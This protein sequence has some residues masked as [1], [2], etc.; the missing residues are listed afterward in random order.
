MR[1]LNGFAVHFRQK[2]LAKA[3]NCYHLQA[4]ARFARS[5]FQLIAFY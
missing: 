4:F 2:Y 3:S 5:C 1:P